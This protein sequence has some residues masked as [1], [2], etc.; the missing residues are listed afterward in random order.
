MT[1]VYVGMV[2]QAIAGDGID[3]TKQQELDNFVTT[4]LFAC[5]QASNSAV[6]KLSNY[7]RKCM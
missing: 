4:L 5:V 7:Y 3:A 2:V 6:T 1:Y